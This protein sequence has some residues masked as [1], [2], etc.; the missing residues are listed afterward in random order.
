[1]GAQSGATLCLAASL[2]WFPVFFHD[3]DA[4]NPCAFPVELET[5]LTVHAPVYDPG[6]NVTK[7]WMLNPTAR[8]IRRAER[9]DYLFLGRV[10]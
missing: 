1:M 10:L 2:A 8:T 5:K 4:A 6:P 3:V 9:C 7:R